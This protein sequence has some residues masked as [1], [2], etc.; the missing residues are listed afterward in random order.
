LGGYCR[1][2]HARDKST[3]EPAFLVVIAE[4]PI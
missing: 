2:H 1:M 4:R 3:E